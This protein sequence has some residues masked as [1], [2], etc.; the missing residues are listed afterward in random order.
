MTPTAQANVLAPRD[1][2]QEFFTGD[3]DYFLQGEERRVVFALEKLRHRL[4]YSVK[5]MRYSP[6]WRDGMQLPNY[7]DRSWKTVE[8]GFQS[9]GHLKE[10]AYRFQLPP[11]A[12]PSPG[13]ELF[14]VSNPVP[15]AQDPFGNS[16]GTRG[17]FPETLIYVD[18]AAKGAFLDRYLV[19]EA[20]WYTYWSIDSLL[21]RTRPHQIAL[22]TWSVF[23]APRGFSEIAVVERDR[24]AHRLF[25]NTKVLA[26]AASVFPAGVTLHQPLDEAAR[27]RV[28]K[29]LADTF[30]ILRL[31]VSGAPPSR[32]ALV[33]ADEFLEAGR[34]ELARNIP[35]R[36]NI[37]GIGH[38]H[39]DTAWQWTLAQGREKLQ[40]TVLNNLYLMDRYP[41]YIFNHGGA[42]HY[43][44]V[45]KQDYP[46]LYRRVKEKIAKGQWD[47]GGGT[48]VEMDV[49]MPSGESLVRQFL[50]AQEFCEKELGVKCQVYWAPDTFGF[51]PSLPG[52]M[53]GFDVKLMAGMRIHPAGMRLPND[54]FRWRGIDGS[55]VLVNAILTRRGEYPLIPDLFP[56]TP[57][58]VRSRTLS[59]IYNGRDPGPRRL[60]GV[61]E[62]FQNKS[63]S[64][65]QIM[66]LGRGD[67]GGGPNEDILEIAR[68][69]SQLPGVAQFGWLRTQ[70][71]ADR[72]VK[73]WDRLATYQ[74]EINVG[75][76]ATFD[77]ANLVKKEN[78]IAERMLHDTEF[79]GAW[80]ARLGKP[81]DRQP[82]RQAW[83]I[84]MVHQFHDIITGQAIDEVYVDAVRDYEKLKGLIRPVLDS[85]ARAIVQEIPTRGDGL[86]IFNTLSFDRKGVQEIEIGSKRVQ[87]GL[88]ASDG[89]LLPTQPVWGSKGKVLVD[90]AAVPAYGYETLQ[91]KQGGAAPRQT[92][93]SIT[94]RV[95]QNRYLRVKLNDKAQ[96][97][98]IYDRA[99]RRE[100]VPTGKLDNALMLLPAPVGPGA[101]AASGPEPQPKIV[102]DLTSFKI[103]ERGPLR[104]AWELKRSFGKSTIVQRIQLRYNSRRIDFVTDMDCKEAEQLKADF[105]LDVNTPVANAEIQ[106]G[107]MQFSRVR[108]TSMDRNEIWAHHWVDV[109]EDDYGVSILNTLK[110]GH[111]VRNGGI[112]IALYPGARRGSRSKGEE[113]SANTFTY[114]LY[115]HAGALGQSDVVQQ[116]YDLNRPLLVYPVA[117]QQGQAPRR[118]GM[119]RVDPANI[120]LDTV[121][122]AE[123][124]DGMI[125]RLYQSAA[126]NSIVRIAITP[127]VA[128]AEL[129]DMR[130]RRLADLSVQKGEIAFPLTPFQ[131]TTVRLRLK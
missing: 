68:R 53:R 13:N 126:R 36:F 92:G 120:M 50:Y 118:Q 91:W 103:V 60:F 20:R 66:S 11:L 85:E 29:L 71:Y 117:A 121:K 111:D 55:E 16:H 62:E 76:E 95:A 101:Q 65:D 33:K 12:A 87:G 54:L 31:D 15:S 127:A 75:F 6:E 10:E 114:S 109:S 79:L 1:P 40:R 83:D 122:P 18:G 24:V 22:K 93:L 104:V 57:A 130:E 80:A 43:M 125:L 89:T 46:D 49:H 39:L 35:P 98:S 42:V 70:D 69:S 110:Y 51:T 48:W 63:A 123:D 100:L 9:A 45:L 107:H 67:G 26:E 5:A 74:G 17:G 84:L 30:A 23:D 44:D 52:I 8:M 102:D 28:K 3:P 88:A 82:V 38:G 124:G 97:V 21:D 131:I 128:G 96:I 129:C 86:V 116:G 27:G 99:A 72:I 112:R 119:F 34:V 113:G 64:N 19:P 94:D 73:S 41:E 61:W 78:R 4:V 81:Y 115:P 47:A 56:D 32:E 77:R 105:P 7:D 37:D 108:N 90:L 2:D 58:A 106:F 59:V 25:W 14:L